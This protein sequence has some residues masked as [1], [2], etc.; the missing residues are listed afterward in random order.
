M[1]NRTKRVGKLYLLWAEQSTILK[2]GYTER[3]VNTRALE[4][5]A[6]S[7]LPLRIL[8]EK[9]GTERDEAMLHRRLRKFRSHG[10]WFS[11][12]ETV[13]WQLLG[14]FGVE[15]PLCRS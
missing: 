2:I 13:V 5:E 11:L 8:A 1:A 14:W 4:I 10:E 3:D 12:P 6:M 15:H 9:I 7:P